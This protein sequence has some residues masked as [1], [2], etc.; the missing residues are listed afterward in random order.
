[1]SAHLSTGMHPQVMC[2]FRDELEKQAVFTPGL[3]LKALRS[4]NPFIRQ[5]GLAGAK[6]QML[7]TE[8]EPA[9][10]GTLEGTMRLSPAYGLASGKAEIAK[11][12]LRKSG[13][14]RRLAEAMT[15]EGGTSP[16]STINPLDVQG[17]LAQKLYSIAEGAA[18]AL[19]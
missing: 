5:L 15:F 19:T 2:F 18:S 8:L 6:G 13:V 10:R 14:G 16:F 4:K 11:L 7:A 1:M 9:V 12:G 3:S 17:P